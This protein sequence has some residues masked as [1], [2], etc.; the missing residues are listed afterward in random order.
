MK[1]LGADI[2]KFTVLKQAS[3]DFSPGVN[4]FIGKNG[5]GKSHLM[6]LLY[7]IIK[8]LPP[9]QTTDRAR[10]FQQELAKKL[11]GVFKPDGQAISRLVTRTTGRAK[12]TI[13]V[14][15]DSGKIAWRLTTLGNLH[16]DSVE[17]SMSGPAIF[18]PS[19]ETLAMYEGF[20]QAYETR[21]LS[22]DETYR[23]ICVLLS[24]SPLLGPRLARARSLA[25]PL[26]KILGGSV[27]LTG[28]RF[29]LTSPEGNLEAHLVAE[30]HRKLASLT[31]LV[32]NG[33]LLQNSV[34]F[35]DEPEANLNPRLVSVVAEILRKLAAFGIQIFVS[36]H[37][38]LLTSEL[39]MA[40]EFSEL[41]PTAES[42]DIRFFGLSVSPDFTVQT[43]NTLA[44]LTDN[45]LVGEFVD[46]YDRQSE[47]M[48]RLLNKQAGASSV[49]GE[50]K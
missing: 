17:A 8:S 37:D 16:V 3:F 39:S 2:R 50:R 33:S 7:A 28:N 46:H 6:K 26:E 20:I 32:L 48:R 38:Y 23:D 14:T 24:G 30:G 44:D 40:M 12:A 41:F 43:G 19:R 9:D 47:F 21:E 35:W 31:H 10:I 42:A 1:I 4:V 13:S 18:L 34:L 27:R 5:S 29:Y 25:E 36:T 11:A 45:D 22:F 49:K 15:T